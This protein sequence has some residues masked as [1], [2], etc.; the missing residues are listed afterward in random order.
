MSQWILGCFLEV[1]VVLHIL[2]S[3]YPWVVDRNAPSCLPTKLSLL[4][5]AALRSSSVSLAHFSLS[6]PETCFHLT[7]T[8]S[9]FIGGFSLCWSCFWFLGGVCVGCFVVALLFVFF[10]GEILHVID[11]FLFGFG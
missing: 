10:F 9:S 4:P 6:L 3:L 2:L 5:S 8:V 11:G 7:M 1:F